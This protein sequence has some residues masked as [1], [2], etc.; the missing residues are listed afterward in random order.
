MR[1]CMASTSHLN[2]IEKYS[3]MGFMG[4]VRED[5]AVVELTW[6]AGADRTT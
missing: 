4:A 2:A 6:E 5:M 1:E 3:Q